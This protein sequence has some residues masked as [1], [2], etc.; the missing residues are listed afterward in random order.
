MSLRLSEINF[1]NE[2]LG[3]FDLSKT[4]YMYTVST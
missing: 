3:T 1:D 4:E 2:N